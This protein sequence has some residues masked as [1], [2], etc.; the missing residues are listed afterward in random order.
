MISNNPSWPM[1][2]SSL[3]SYCPSLNYTHPYWKW[4]SLDSLIV[5]ILSGAQRSGRNWEQSSL[6]APYP[7]HKSCPGNTMMVQDHGERHLGNPLPWLFGLVLPSS[8]LPLVLQKPSTDTTSS[9]KPSLTYLLKLSFPLGYLSTLCTP[10][11]HQTHCADYVCT[12][13]PR[14]PP[15][16]QQQIVSLEGS[17]AIWFISIVQGRGGGSENVC[18]VNE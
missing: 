2:I 6:V 1:P 8:L 13:V 9:R 12:S 14:S 10:P 5:A 3:R 11:S 16:A 7:Q 4:S 18:W 17:N 15:P